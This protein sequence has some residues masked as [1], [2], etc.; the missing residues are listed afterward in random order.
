[1]VFFLLQGTAFKNITLHTPM[2]KKLYPFPGPGGGGGG[3]YD[4]EGSLLSP[5]L[6]GNLIE[7]DG[8]PFDNQQSRKQR[9]LMNE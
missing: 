7:T 8:F 3:G 5:D 6:Y 9:R 1:M 2:L 4:E